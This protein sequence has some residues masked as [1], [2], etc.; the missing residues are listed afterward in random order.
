ML[1]VTTLSKPENL[2]RHLPPPKSILVRARTLAR[3]RADANLA[4]TAA[5]EKIVAKVKAAVTLRSKASQILGIDG[6][7]LLLIVSTR[8]A[9]QAWTHRINAMIGNKHNGF[10]S[11]GIGIGLRVRHYQ[12]LLSKKPSVDWLEIISENYMVDGGRPIEILDEILDSQRVIQHGVS[13]YFGSS[14]PYERSHLDR[15]KRLVKKTRTPFISDHLCW[16]SFDGTYSHDLLPIPFTFQMA[17]NTADRIKFVRDY[18]EVPI[19]V[20]N[21]SSYAEF[22]DS[23]M[24]EYQFLSEV[25]ELADCGILLD[26]NNIYVS[27]QN[28]DFDPYEYL[29]NV[30]LDRVGQIHLAGHSVCDNYLLDTHDGPVDDNVWRLFERMIE[31]VGPTNILLEWDSNI[32]SFEEVYK[33]AL[34]AENYLQTTV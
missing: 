1:A 4:I 10:T 14:D 16:G 5:K 22:I 33:E 3:A 19:C 32:P 11:Y 18:L 27:S 12:H 30:P 24:A 15:L 23:E 9:S 31:R 2:H 28:H 7:Q 29:E 13:L 8:L 26:V 20:E 34:K 6:K 17:R 21:I 25:C